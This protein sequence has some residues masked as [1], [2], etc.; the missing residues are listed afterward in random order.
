MTTRAQVR[1]F[2]DSSTFLHDELPDGPTVEILLAID[3]CFKKHTGAQLLHEKE[4]THD[5]AMY[6]AL[7]L[8]AGCRNPSKG[9]IDKKKMKLFSSKVKNLKEKIKN[10][11]GR[12]RNP[13]AAFSELIRPLDVTRWLQFSPFARVLKKT[14]DESGLTPLQFYELLCPNEAR[15]RKA[16]HDIEAC[17]KKYVIEAAGTPAYLR[18][19]DYLRTATRDDFEGALRQRMKDLKHLVL[20]FFDVPENVKGL[21]KVGFGK[22]VAVYYSCNQS[23]EVYHKFKQ[24]FPHLHFPSYKN[25]QE[26]AREQAA[27]VLSFDYG[28][29]HLGAEVSLKETILKRLQQKNVRDFTTSLDFFPSRWVVTVHLMHPFTTHC[30]NRC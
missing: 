16:H 7:H 25:L 4:L 12:L 20:Q 23:K 28:G 5:Q 15:E 11:C 30:C 21:I 10:Y 14:L 27:K 9:E 3:E 1:N 24:F 22:A 8:F 17:A 6:Q 13:K 2:L 26:H 19:F 29:K 18:F